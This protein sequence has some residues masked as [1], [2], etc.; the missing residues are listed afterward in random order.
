MSDNDFTVLSSKEFRRLREELEALKGKFED[1]S[2]SNAWVSDLYWQGRYAQ[3]QTK[4]EILSE[5]YEEL[6]KKQESSNGN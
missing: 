1:Q 2:R 3:I 6:L 4:Y 5:K